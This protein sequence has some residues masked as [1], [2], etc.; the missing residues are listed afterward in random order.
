MVKMHKGGNSQSFFFMDTHIVCFENSDGT[1]T[2]IQSDY[3][4]RARQAV[5]TFRRHEINCGLEPRKYEIFHRDE[6]EWIE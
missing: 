3:I 4:D 6:V 1:Y 5:V 2:A